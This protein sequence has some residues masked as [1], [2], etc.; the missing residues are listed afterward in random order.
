MPLVQIVVAAGCS[1]CQEAR[2][3]ADEA[4]RRFPAATVEVIDLDAEPGHR[5][6]SVFAVPTYLLDGRIVSLGTP[7]AA[8]F[9]HWIAERLTEP[10]QPVAEEKTE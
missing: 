3:L 7:N 8:E 4:Q 1:G 10:G 5:P 6:A 2:R 9:Y